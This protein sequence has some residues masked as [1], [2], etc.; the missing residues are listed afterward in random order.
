MTNGITRH[1]CAVDGGGTGCRAVIAGADGTVLAKVSG[2]R[3]NFTTNRDVAAQSVLDAVTK[4]AQSL[5]DTVD[6]KRIVAH[7][8]LAG[9]LS[10][11]DASDLADRLPFDTCT[12]TDDRVT[13][14]FGVLGNRDGAVLAIGTGSFVAARRGTDLNFWGGWGFRVGD[15]ASGAWLGRAVLEHCL[16]AHEGLEPQSD[17]TREILA[18]FTDTSANIAAFAA[19]AKTSEFAEFSPLIVA[20]ARNDDAVGRMLMTR[21]ANYLNKT[22]KSAKITDQDAICLTGGVG[23]HYESYL[24]PEYRARIQPPE[25]VALDGALQLARQNLEEMEKQA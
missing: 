20:A 15:Q 7:V 14:A 10:P 25:G 2:G 4:A 18:R 6:L 21:G 8:G 16:L 5:N 17:L 24:A 11:Q 9:I 22:L 19:R 13:S 12:V 23:P 3:A 1:I